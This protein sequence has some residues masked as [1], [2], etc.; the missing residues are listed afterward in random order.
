MPFIRIRTGPDTD[1]DL[2]ITYDAIVVGLARQGE[3]AAHVPDVA[4]DESPDARS[5]QEDRHQQ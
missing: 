1:V 5:R 2:Q 4:R 3:W